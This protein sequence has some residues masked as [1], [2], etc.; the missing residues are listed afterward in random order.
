MI[1]ISRETICNKISFLNKNVLFFIFRLSTCNGELPISKSH[2]P[3]T[4]TATRAA[5]ASPT[6]GSSL[7]TTNP[8]NS[9]HLHHSLHSNMHS[10]KLSP[11]S[12]RESLHQQK[13]RDLE[14][15]RDRSGEQLPQMS[16]AGTDG[17]MGPHD[18]LLDSPSE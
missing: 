17:S 2:G 8:I 14:R 10:L 13:D 4:A 6:A 15:E 7:S 3:V 9:H 12:S 11:S 18:L 16:P 5:S 1:R